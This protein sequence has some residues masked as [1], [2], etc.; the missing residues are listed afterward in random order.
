MN[1]ANCYAR[2][3][4]DYQDVLRRLGTEER[5]KR[6]LCRLPEDHNYADLC[7]AL[8]EGRGEDAFRAAHSLKGICMN[9]GLTKLYRSTNALT[10]AL[11]GGVIPAAAQPLAE[12]VGRDYDETVQCV[13]ALLQP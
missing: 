13:D 11:R 8:Q 3:E 4:A 6:F 5:V 1:V 12:Q 9:L 2:M 10:E 7:S